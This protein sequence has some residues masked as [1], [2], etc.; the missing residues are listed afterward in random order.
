MYNVQCAN[1][2]TTTAGAE[3]ESEVTF[4]REE[5]THLTDYKFGDGVPQA[6]SSHDT[7][8]ARGL[9]GGP[10]GS[11]V[12][13]A[14]DLFS[15]PDPTLAV[16]NLV[17]SFPLADCRLAHS[18]GFARALCLDCLCCSFCDQALMLFVHML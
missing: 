18:L 10:M 6:L 12:H 16:R 1:L 14:T 4:E 8:D 15:L 2:S 5:A 9:R 13:N 11:A 3:S 7:P 17:R